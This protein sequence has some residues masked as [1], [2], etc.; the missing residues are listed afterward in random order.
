M[1]VG[2]RPYFRADFRMP[3][4][5]GGMQEVLRRMMGLGPAP[6][7]KPWAVKWLLWIN[8]VVFIFQQFLDKSPQ[9]EVAGPLSEIL[10]VTVGGGGRCGGMLRPSSCTRASCTSR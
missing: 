4:G 1:G 10:G 2:D 7:P 9:P 8:I 5:M 6:G 3:G